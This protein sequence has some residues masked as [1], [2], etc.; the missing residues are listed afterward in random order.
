MEKKRILFIA[1]DA[2]AYGANQ[3]LMNIIS[4]LR[5]NNIYVKVLF[6]R[7]G[8][9]CDIFDNK[10][11]DY[12]IIR[13]RNEL[14]PAVTNLKS[15]IKIFRSFC[16]K[17]Y[18]NT[19]AKR[20]ISALI[21]REN[22]NIIHSNSGVLSIGA[23]IASKLNIKH[24]WHLREFIHPNYG[25]YLFTQLGDYKR[26]IQG[27]TN[28]LCVSNKV[29]EE[30]DITDKATVIYDAIRK[31]MKYSASQFKEDYFLFCGSLHKNKGIEEAIMAIKSIS[32]QH[33]EVKL[34]IVGEGTSEYERY[35]RNLINELSLN[36]NIYFLGFRTD[37]D[38]LMAKAKALLMCSR[39]EALGRVTAEAMLNY[40]LVLGFDDGGTSELIK[41]R[42]T[43]LLYNSIEKLVTLMSEVIENTN[44][45]NQ[46]VD[47]AADFARSNF[48]ERAFGISLIKYYDS[49]K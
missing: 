46:I 27:S 25:L 35:L 18:V 24:I 28:L 43:G 22:I 14:R 20:E 7:N 34:L 30:F 10:G 23:E 15:R 33:Q 32:L 36:E 38:E 19:L 39:N 5:D 3:S 6:P 47:N 31:N 26:K 40:C 21:K 11:W 16:Y 45:F 1:H 42:K 44:Q 29:A 9:I 41:D 49:L 48:L 8:I 4:V 12:S 2:L 17:K 37:I 13:Y